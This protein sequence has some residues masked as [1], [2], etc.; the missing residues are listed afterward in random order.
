MKTKIKLGMGLNTRKS[1]SRQQQQMIKKCLGILEKTK[2]LTENTLKKIQNGM[3]VLRAD[4]FT[5][6]IKK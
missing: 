4:A 6:T 2:V 1:Q 5:N 3:D